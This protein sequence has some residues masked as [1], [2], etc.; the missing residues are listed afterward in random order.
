M[1]SVVST[2]SNELTREPPEFS[3][4]FSVI[5]GV[6]SAQVRALH[7]L[8]LIWFDYIARLYPNGEEGGN[9]SFK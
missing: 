1:Y 9:S 2:Q 8:N 4:A 3:S 6:T 5:A 7:D